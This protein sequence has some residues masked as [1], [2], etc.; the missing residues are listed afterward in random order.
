MVS[1]I[2][3]RLRAAW[4]ALVSA[5]EPIAKPQPE[6]RKPLKIN[7]LSLAAASVSGAPVA[8]PWKVAK[9][10]PGVVPA[11]VDL[12]MDSDMSA[13]YGYAQMDAISEGLVFLGH[14]YL[15]EL[16]QR[17]EYR[18]PVEILAKEMT[19]KWIKIQATGDASEDEGGDDKA[20][21]IR[22]IETE[23]ERLKVRDVFREALE[24]D[25]FF[26]RS[27]IFLDVG[28]DDPIELKTALS[29]S[30]TKI[31]K[32]AL[33]CLR[34]I[35]PLWCYP[36]AY[37]SNNPLKPG[38]FRPTSW[39]V[40]GQQVHASR[41]MTVVSREVP[42]ML[43][44]AYAFGGLSLSQ[45]M[46]P[47]VDNWL[48]TRQSVSDLI[49]SFTIYVLK[50]NMSGVLEGEGGDDFKMRVSL[51]SKYRDNHGTLAIDKD[52]E[53]F[54]NIAAPLG[55]LDHLQAQAQE[56]MSAVSGIPLV[57]LL[58][59][60]PTG[61]NASSDGEIKVFY[62]WISAQQEGVIRPHLDRLFKVVQL[63]LY[64]EIDPEIGYVFQP[65]EQLDES[66]IASVRKTEAE[67][68][69]ALIDKGVIDPAEARKRLAN[70]PDSP[71]ASL[72][73]N[74][75]IEPPA[76][77]GEGGLPG[78]PGANPGAVPGQPLPPAMDPQQQQQGPQDV[79]PDV[80][81]FER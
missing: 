45:L 39:F 17:A 38:F 47:Y 28:V 11:G 55:S 64:G 44:P 51:F 78:F 27:H 49:H 59:I 73:L 10:P 67:T 7:P 41:L 6:Q 30:V 43:K 58:G 25:G 48:R 42:D 57:K 46:K 5:P 21:K 60:T 32:G 33:K 20:E 2:L 31:S 72:D 34:V 13:L 29:E 18:R 50:T 62:D 26:G 68:D 74:K 69:G 8:S 23:M 54:Q 80:G 40:L 63:S 71:Y 65:L 35:E 56:Q 19:R 9:P 52:T 4:R 12:A 15:A 37:N 70:Q 22:A 81:S 1:R 77:G 79:A 75:V 24:H 76:E 16:A 36:D 14:P 61:L 3:E 66:E 53:D